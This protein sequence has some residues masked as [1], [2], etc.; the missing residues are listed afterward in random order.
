MKGKFLLVVP[1]GLWIA[2]SAPKDQVPEQTADFCASIHRNDSISLSQSLEALADSMRNK[3]GVYVLEDGGGSLVARAWLTEYAEKTIDIQYFIFSPDNVGL[4][5]CDYLVRA[6]DRGVKVRLLVDDIMVEAGVHEIVTLDSHEN[7][8][9]RIYNPGVN[10]G[11]NLFSKLKKYTTEFRSANQRMHNKTF[12][13]DG[14]VTITGGRNIADEYF[15]Y[16]HEYNFRDRD[17]LLMGKINATIEKSFEAFWESPLS[18]PVTKLVSEER[19]GIDSTRFDRLHQYA[20]NPENFW[21]QVRARIQRL[22]EAF[23]ALNHSGNI[24]WLDR[25]DFVS[26]VPGKNEDEGLHGGGITT[27]TLISLIRNAKTSLEIQSPYLVTTKLA[28]GLFRDAVKRGVKVRILTNSMAS[29][30][31]ME[32]FSGYQRDR[33]ELLETGVQIYEF[34]PDAKERYQVMTGALQ[35]KIDFT[36]IFGLHAKSMV[37]DGKITVIGTF[38]LDPRSANLNTE[39]IAV[40]HSEKIAAG[41]LKGMEEEFKPE[42]AWETTLDFNPDS[43]AAMSKRVKAFT[44]KVVPKNI[45]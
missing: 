12:I 8:D 28:R 41:V 19:V 10:L 37:V 38:N 31:N 15:D 4:I 39:C 22:P 30:D 36:P 3:T 25:V 5:A 23:A 16:D 1:V 29:T 40:I 27:D 33:K 35:E 32:A 43:E 6:A 11:K 9:I 26:D 17:V 42:N 21:P 20:C 18:V 7:I 45:L 13:V 44:R 2:C 14:K 34:R 24:V